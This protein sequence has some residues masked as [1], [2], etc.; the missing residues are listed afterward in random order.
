MAPPWRYR[1]RCAA[2]GSNESAP[3]HQPNDADDDHEQ[4]EIAP[5]GAARNHPHDCADD[6]EWYDQPIGP[7]EK[8]NERDEREYERDRAYDERDQVEHRR[9]LSSYS[10][11]S[12]GAIRAS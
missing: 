7:A 8:R 10:A 2:R 3:E 1:R 11:V 4:V 5:A 6:R 9:A 12:T